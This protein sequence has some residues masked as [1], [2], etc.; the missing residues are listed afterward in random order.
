MALGPFDSFSFPNVY[1]K[2]LN[3]APLVTAAGEL[4]VPAFIGVGQENIP[5]KNYEMIRGSSSLADNKITR[6]NVS[7]QLTGTNRNFTVTYYP[8]VSGDGTGTVTNDPDNVTVEVDGEP[9]AVSSVDGDTGEIYL[10]NIPTS[11]AVVLCTYYFNRKDTLHTNEDLS[12]QVDGTRTVFR[13]HYTPIV[14]GDNGGITTTNTSDVT[15]KVGVGGGI[16]V[17]V[18]VSAVD[19]DSGQITL[20]AA[21]GIGDK[22][23]VTYYSNEYPETSDILPSPYV[24]AIDKVGYAP[25]TS[26][27]VKN[28]D[29]VLDTTGNFHTINWGHSFKIASGQH[30]IA[31]EYFDDTQITGTLYDNRVWRRATTGTV[32]GTN[33]TFTLEATPVAG[34][35]RGITT[36]DPDLVTAYYGTSPTDATTVDVIQL[37]GVAKTALLASAPPV[38]TKVYVTQYTNLLPDDTFTLTNTL[39]GAADIGTY[40]MEAVNAGTCMDV[41]WS[42]ADTTVADP[43]FAS[44]NVT[45]PNGT[46]PDNRD[47]QVSPGY[48]VSE[49]VFLTFADAT[50]YTVSSSNAN[51]SGSA[52]D[53][54]GYLNQTY[55]DTKTGFRVTINKG[56]L[57]DY[58]TGDKIGYK[59]SS[60]FVTGTTPTRAIPGLRTKVANTTDIGSGDTATINTYNKSGSEPN[61]G[62]FYYISY[63]ETKQFDD[64]GLTT[65]KLYTQEKDVFADT[66]P[67]TINNK[68][69]LA[70]HL[71]FLN[72]ATAIALLQIQKA[73]GSDDAPDSRYIAGIDY[74][75]EPMKNNIRPVLMEPVTTSD[76]V[77]SYLKTSNTIQ[78]GIRYAN[79]RYSYFGFANN[80]TPTTAQAI[81]RALNSE[82]M[83]AVYPDG[84]ITTI[85]DELGTTVEYLVDGSIMAA[86]IVGRDVSPAFDVSEPL[87]RKPIV[88]LTR[89]YR[90][91]DSVTAAQTA[92]AGITLFE[93]LAS[94]MEIKF[95]LTTDVSSVLTRTPS[96]IRTKDSIQTGARSA[97]APYIGKKLLTQRLTE[98][99]QTL[100]SYLSALQQAQI[101]TA[102]TGVKAKV[103]PNDPTIV[104]VEAF[105]SPVFPLLWIV[106]T[107]NLR[108]SI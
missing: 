28:T 12:D 105:Y 64:N 102:F 66:G 97:L 95:A 9:V 58:Q 45:Y 4:R 23:F 39:A 52:G 106:I 100:T 76:A 48:A 79:E 20:A 80:T 107:F 99:E 81:A 24:T 32:D 84:A 47:T 73:S 94:G 3:E 10:V 33:A 65:A 30:T 41:T 69:G 14:K 44:E 82:R 21:P 87:T 90:R 43:D 61:I 22:V 8:I 50:T 85:T 68:I 77:I 46:G 91:M 29:F 25:G 59:V 15:V 27:F 2:T 57:V 98:I 6:E 53:N 108:S 71:A 63:T 11:D 17:A 92:N 18:T 7:S 93:D 19:G 26:D 35:G 83:I 5:V 1:T 89:L 40:T 38:G 36:D 103:D 101:I 78:S 86:A 60:T 49:T 31:S 13:T 34:T 55:I 62:D 54:T 104:N 67:L 96:I 37:N 72:G 88:G 75:N 16:P 74:F 42:T 70:A 51:G 56:A